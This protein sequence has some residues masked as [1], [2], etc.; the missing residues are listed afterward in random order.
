MCAREVPRH[1]H[2]N[3]HLLQLDQGEGV[4]QVRSDTILREPMRPRQEQ[5]HDHQAEQ[6]NQHEW[7]YS[8]SG[9]KYVKISSSWGTIKGKKSRT[10]R[11]RVISSKKK[12]VVVKVKSTKT[13]TKSFTI[14][15]NG[16]SC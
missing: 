8:V 10:I 6:P 16:K 5:V 15:T 13:P 7:R 14:A 4:R 1:L 3:L 2:A 12:C 11:V 9:S